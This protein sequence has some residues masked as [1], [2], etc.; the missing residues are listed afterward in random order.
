MARKL[1][2]M[3]PPGN[4]YFPD[5]EAHHNGAR[6]FHK[7]GVVLELEPQVSLSSYLKELRAGTLLACDDATA[8]LAGVDMHKADKAGKKG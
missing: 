3:V 2:V 8:K 6:R 5:F 1:L 7:P 4:E